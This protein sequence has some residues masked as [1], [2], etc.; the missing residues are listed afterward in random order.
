[1]QAKKKSNFENTGYS[2][3]TVLYLCPE[4]ASALKGTVSVASSSVVTRV[5]YGLDFRDFYGY[6]S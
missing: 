1:M 2:A 4:S 5:E 6:S 3:C